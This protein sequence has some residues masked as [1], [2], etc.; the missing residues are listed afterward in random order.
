[1]RAA[2]L[3]APAAACAR[4]AALVS[5]STPTAHV[6]ADAD[7]FPIGVYPLRVGIGARTSRLASF[8]YFPSMAG[9]STLSALRSAKVICKDVNGIFER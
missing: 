7:A 4:L 3:L 5:P 2:D 8:T 1:M 6:S 9:N